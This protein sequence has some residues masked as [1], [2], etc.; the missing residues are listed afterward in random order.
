MKNRDTTE[1]DLDTVFQLLPVI[2][3]QLHDIDIV[4]SA[5]FAQEDDEIK[6]ESYARIYHPL[7]KSWLSAKKCN[8]ELCVHFCDFHITEHIAAYARQ[9]FDSNATGLNAL[10]WDTAEVKEIGVASEMNYDDAFT[11]EEVVDSHK[12]Y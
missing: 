7:T 11:I 4:S 1:T 9:Q 6:F 12:L 5:I 2:E 10:Q 3:V 8:S